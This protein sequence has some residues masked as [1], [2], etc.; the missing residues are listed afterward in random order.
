MLT[1]YNDTFMDSILDFPR[2]GRYNYKTPAVDVID[3]GDRYR[4]KM[5]VPGYTK[6]D[7]NIIVEDNQL[8]VEGENKREEGNFLREEI[9]YGKLYRKVWINADTDP[10]SVR[11]RLDQGMLTITLDK[12]TQKLQKT[13][14]IE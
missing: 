2:L 14:K 4:V 10:D 8:T 6:E 3:T 13:I 5:A 11:A 1:R 12:E 9:A 7:L